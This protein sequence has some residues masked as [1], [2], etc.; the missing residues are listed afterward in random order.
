MELGFTRRHA[1]RRGS[2]DHRAERALAVSAPPTLGT[3]YCFAGSADDADGDGQSQHASTARTAR[4]VSRF[5]PSAR[6]L[7]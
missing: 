4:D 3:A 7:V 5:H 1:H 6:T 2:L